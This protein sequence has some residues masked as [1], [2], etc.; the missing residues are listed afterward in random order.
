MICLGHNVMH[1]THIQ[2]FGYGMVGAAATT[3][4]SQRSIY[5][6]VANKHYTDRYVLCVW[7]GGANSSSSRVNICVW[8]ARSRERNVYYVDA[9]CY[10]TIV[11][12]VYD[13]DNNNALCLFVVVW[14]RYD[15]GGAIW[16]AILLTVHMQK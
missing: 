9:R 14:S 2:H 13:H 12:N 4:N 15:S 10:W 7:F 1:C 5:I 16:V 8:R 11:P 6:C 3:L